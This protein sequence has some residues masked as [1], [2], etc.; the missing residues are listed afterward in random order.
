MMSSLFKF[1]TLGIPNFRLRLPNFFSS[2][3]ESRSFLNYE[4]NQKCSLRRRFKRSYE[5][6][7]SSLKSSLSP[8]EFNHVCSVIENKALKTK[9]RDSSKLEK[10]FGNLK[11]N[12]RNW[13]IDGKLS[14]YLKFVGPGQTLYFT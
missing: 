6:A 4:L 10:K 12:F 11:R 7:R 8:L 3:L 9:E 2:L 14:L 1:E 5:S 13:R